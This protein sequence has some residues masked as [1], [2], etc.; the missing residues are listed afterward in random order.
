VKAV[1]PKTSRA[2]NGRTVR[3]CPI[4]PPTKPLTPTSSTN[5]PAFSRRPSLG[6]GTVVIARVW[7]ARYLRKRAKARRTI[8]MASAPPTTATG[9][10]E[11]GMGRNVAPAEVTSM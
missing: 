4:I 11:R 7:A 5:W 8:P 2:I 9:P 1:S 6:I 3:S 10:K